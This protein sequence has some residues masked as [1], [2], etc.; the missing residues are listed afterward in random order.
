M[1]P[2]LLRRLLNPIGDEVAL[3]PERRDRAADAF[4]G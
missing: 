1:R 4:A 2:P 3:R